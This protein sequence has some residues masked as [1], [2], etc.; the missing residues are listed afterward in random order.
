MERTIFLAVALFTMGCAVEDP[1]V[2]MDLRMTQAM[3]SGE[4]LDAREALCAFVGLEASCVSDEGPVP[5]P[6]PVTADAGFFWAVAVPL[7]A[8]GWGQRYTLRGSFQNTEGTMTGSITGI[9]VEAETG[10]SRILADSASPSNAWRGV[11]AGGI[12]PLEG[13]PTRGDFD[14]GWAKNAYADMGFL[15]G[16]WRGEGDRLGGRLVGSFD[17]DTAQ[18]PVGEGVD[19]TGD[20]P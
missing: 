6:P 16:I 15:E 13:D 17:F 4:P 7:E 9:I 10:G 20:P 2:E 12:V 3:A 18:V 14:G 5:P 1:K 8:D 19:P 11:V